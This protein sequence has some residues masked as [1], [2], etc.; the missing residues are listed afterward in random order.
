MAGQFSSGLSSAFGGGPIGTLANIGG[1]AAAPF[2]GG[3]SL[4]VPLAVG[5]TRGAASGG[6]GGALG[7]AVGGSAIAGLGSLL[8][9]ANPFGATGIFGSG[10]VGPGIT[11]SALNGSATSNLMA[12]STA[13]SGNAAMTAPTPTF[14]NSLNNAGSVMGG[15]NLINSAM[16]SNSA[17]PPQLP[18]AS[19]LSMPG[20]GPNQPGS[21]GYRY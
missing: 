13:W 8:P 19:S 7:G 20:Y 6:I 14:L 11:S 15:A 3:A 5:A 17:P 18:P 12:P 21:L 4:A 9:G 2:T 16:S 10:T 1:I